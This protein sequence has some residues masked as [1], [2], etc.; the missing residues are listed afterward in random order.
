MRYRTK[1]KLAFRLSENAERDHI[2]EGIRL[3]LECN[4]LHFLIGWVANY[5]EISDR[6]VAAL[7]NPEERGSENEK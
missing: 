3:A 2:K 4:S 5:H 1:H 7:H 6:E